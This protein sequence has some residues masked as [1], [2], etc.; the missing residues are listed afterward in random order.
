M[1]SYLT[2]EEI[3]LRQRRGRIIYT[4]T[5]ILT[6]IVGLY[7]VWAMRALILP[8][9]I[10][11]VMAYICLPLIGY[12]KDKGFSR[13]W[14]VICLSGLFC[15]ILFSTINLAAKV[16]PDQKTEL[17][18]Q[19]RI[20][21]KINE[22]FNQ[23]MGL[24]EN[25]RGG[26]WFYTMMGKELEPLRENLDK[27]LRLSEED[28]QL[29]IR[30]YHDATELKSGPVEEQYWQYYQIDQKRDQEKER[31]AKKKRLEDEAHG[32]PPLRTLEKAPGASSLLLLIFN[33]VS[34]WL[35][36]P[37]IFLIL[38]FDDGKLKRSLVQAM[39]NRY[40]EMSLTV[41][42]NINEALGRYLR[43]TSIECFL[44]GTSFTICLFLI[45]LDMQWAATIG[46]IAGLANAIPFLGPIIGLV[47]SMAYA[48]LNED[49]S[50]I[51]PFVNSDNLLISIVIVVALVQ[52]A[53]NA[54]FQPY[55]LGGATDLHP[56][57]VLLGVMGGAVI[58]GFAGMLFAIPTIMVTRVVLTTIFKQFRAYYI[59]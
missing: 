52:L 5:A 32:R 58:F 48:M 39:P 3:L 40:F 24:D 54:I 42:D 45:G 2:S 23:V 21:Y 47:V 51:L 13:F 57:I 26:N 11:M 34:L 53:D 49:I 9:F 10:G 7:L 29:F 38:L 30:Y 31:L 17:E 35:I 59:I 8:A 50:P 20:R 19:V 33:A 27:V 37:L 25:G 22:K 28:R 55:V 4:V 44:V 14:A 56:L 46:I 15:L 16:I 36:T 41:L 18:L 12:L 43:G 6:V 1:N